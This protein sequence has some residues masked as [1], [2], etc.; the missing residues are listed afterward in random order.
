M[1]NEILILELNSASQFLP[2]VTLG[3][4]K[5]ILV[6]T[7]EQFKSLWEMIG[8]QYGFQTDFDCEPD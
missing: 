7:E 3:T 6:G 1:E 5:V 8:E 2:N 4:N